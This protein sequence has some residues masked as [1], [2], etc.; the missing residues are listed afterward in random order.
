[1]GASIQ[2]NFIIP[3]DNAGFEKVALNN[4]LAALNSNQDA[5]D[6]KDQSQQQHDQQPPAADDQAQ[7]NE[8][9]KE[10][11]A[12][13]DGEETD[14]PP[15]TLEE[16]QQLPQAEA[17]GGEDVQREAAAL[18]ITVQ[19]LLK[20][21]EQDG[22]ISDLFYNPY[23]EPYIVQSVPRDLGIPPFPPGVQKVYIPVE[24]PPAPISAEVNPCCE[25]PIEINVTNIFYSEFTWNEGESWTF[26]YYSEENTSLA[27]WLNSQYTFTFKGCSACESD[28]DSDSG[29]G[30]QIE[31]TA[32]DGNEGFTSGVISI[33][34]DYNVDCDCPIT[35]IEINLYLQ[36]W[37]SS[38]A[39]S[40]SDFNSVFGS[41]FD[42]LSQLAYGGFETEG[43]YAEIFFLS[44]CGDEY[45][46]VSGGSTDWELQSVEQT[47]P[48][49]FDLNGDGIHLSSA[50]TSDVILNNNGALERT[51]WIDSSDGILTYG[52]SGEGAIEHK[53]F[54][55]TENVEGAK[56]DL[57]ALQ[58]LAKQSGGILDG[59]NPIWDNLGMWQDGNLNGAMDKG[60]YQTLT[61]LGI[62]SI[63]LTQTGAAYL[64][65]GNVVYGNL[66]FTYADGKVGH[67]ENVGLRYEDVIQS[68]SSIPNLP[69]ND[70]ST[71]AQSSGSVPVA[72]T[73]VPLQIDPTVQSAIDTT[74]QQP[75]AVAA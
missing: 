66:S 13:K 48:I 57:D 6:A 49:I 59:N 63:S 46:L 75:V 58:A 31:Y 33:P 54:A 73:V 43:G 12:A 55:L 36:D 21:F 18:N 22:N 7:P 10:E 47:A 26:N 2:K 44:A 11:K 3:T 38:S 67:A 40:E 9:D 14:K 23:G 70:N 68:N 15:V 4:I 62:S 20:L 8:G 34:S 37:S 42:N 17:D 19:Q 27:A 53:N 1:M 16:A 41:E 30:S 56:T 51:G 29:S 72:D 32:P 69:S 64:E 45:Q 65:N 28:S 60:E 25:V 5:N 61:Q 74:Q 39:P 50:S 52:Y 24:I 71:V 35:S